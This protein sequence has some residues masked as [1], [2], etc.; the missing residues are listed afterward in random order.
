MRFCR[1][2]SAANW[3]ENLTT[4]E[5]DAEHAIALDAGNAEAYAALGYIAFSRRQ[6]IEM[7]GPRT[8]L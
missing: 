4:A 7:V 3:A 8:G 5:T 2:M 6:Y 1:S